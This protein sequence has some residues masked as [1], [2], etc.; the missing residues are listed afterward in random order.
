MILRGRPP[1]LGNNSATTPYAHAVHFIGD[2]TTPSNCTIT[3]TAG[4]CFQLI[5]G[6]S[7]HIDG[8][9]LIS[10]SG[11]GVNVAYGAVVGIGHI[12]YGVCGQYHIKAGF[13][14]GVHFDN[15]YTVSGGALS[16]MFVYSRGSIENQGGAITATMVG[17]P[18]FPSGVFAVQSGALI[19]ANLLTISGNVNAASPAYALGPFGGDILVGGFGTDLNTLV[20]NAAA[21]TFSGNAGTV[22]GL[23]FPATFTALS[24]TSTLGYATGAGGTV[25][26][27]TSKAT[28]VTLNKATGQITMNNA[29]LAA[30]AVVSFTLTNSGIAATDTVAVNLKS[31]NATAATYRVHAEAPA[32]GSCIIVLTNISAGSLSEALVL[33]FNVFKG[34]N[35]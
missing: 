9:K 17:T 3:A 33:N 13:G 15:S 30:G 11:S 14:P 34:V 31:G 5:N 27:A 25:T 4:D 6:A 35:A 20:P 28:G 7:A 16:H 18:A 21:G 19:A 12:E 23:N 1:G 2:T 10:T 8:F 29:A 32:A 22:N 24:A 26:Q